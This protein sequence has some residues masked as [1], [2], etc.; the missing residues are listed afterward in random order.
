METAVFI[1]CHEIASDGMCVQDAAIS[2]A[3]CAN[4]ARAEDRTASAHV[5]D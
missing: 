3:K 2:C 1:S 5:R 4:A